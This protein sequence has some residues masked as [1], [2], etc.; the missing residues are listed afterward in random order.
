VDIVEIYKD[1]T[2]SKIAGSLPRTLAL[3]GEP[4]RSKTF[5][6]KYFA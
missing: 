2:T 5:N 1:Y 6:P 4:A 3:K